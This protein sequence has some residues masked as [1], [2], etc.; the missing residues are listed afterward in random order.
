MNTSVPVVLF[1]RDVPD[2]PPKDPEQADGDRSEHQHGAGGG[3]ED[4]RGGEDGV[5]PEEVGE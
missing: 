5:G 3:V 4:G 2:L 1:P